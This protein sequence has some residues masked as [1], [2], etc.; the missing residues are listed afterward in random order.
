MVESSSG[1][2]SSP[3]EALYTSCKPTSRSLP[4]EIGSI[5]YIND[6]DDSK[7]HN[8][9]IFADLTDSNGVQFR[10]KVATGAQVKIL[11]K[12]IFVKLGGNISQLNH[13]KATLEGYSGT[14]LGSLG[15]VCIDCRPVYSDMDTDSVLFI[16]TRHGKMPILGLK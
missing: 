14:N 3:S 12:C 4:Y 13:S 2:E 15:I 6:I 10:V 11:P 9:Q 7:R 5:Y 8:E 16:I 1:T